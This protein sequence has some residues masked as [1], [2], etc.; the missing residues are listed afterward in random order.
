MA[1]SSV[2][3]DLYSW[4]VVPPADVRPEVGACGVVFKDRS[5]AFTVVGQ[6]LREAPAGSRALLHKV[7][8]GR[9]KTGYCYEALLARAA[10]DQDT[11]AIVWQK[12]PTPAAWADGATTLSEAAEAMDPP[13]PPE[14]ISASLADAEAEHELQ[15]P[16]GR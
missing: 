3:P 4:T 6:A 10:V 5:R 7:S 12:F 14:A 2:E 13:L 8:L 11:K 15:E 1:R 9:A 16:G